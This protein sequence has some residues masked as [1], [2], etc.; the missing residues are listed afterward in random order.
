MK[1]KVAVSIN[2]KQ[3]NPSCLI[4]NWAKHVCIKN[5]LYNDMTCMLTQANWYFLSFLNRFNPFSCCVKLFSVT[6]DAKIQIFGTILVVVLYFIMSFLDK[7]GL[8]TVLRLKDWKGTIFSSLCVHYLCLQMKQ[9]FEGHTKK[10]PICN[11]LYSCLIYWL[12]EQ[13]LFIDIVIIIMHWQ[14]WPL[15]CV[16][17][18]IYVVLLHDKHL[19][20]FLF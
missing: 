7:R 20:F 9:L 12:G 4:L 17:V 10:D 16:Y 5:I 1:I 3:T 11:I 19:F 13:W 6:D 2:C 8:L 15:Y 18:F 14:Q